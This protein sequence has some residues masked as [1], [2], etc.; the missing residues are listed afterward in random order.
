M[1]NYYM[2]NELIKRKRSPAELLSNGLPLAD[3][4]ILEDLSIN[5]G[6]IWNREVTILNCDVEKLNCMMVYFDKPVTFKN[7]RFKNAIFNFAYFQ[8][9]LLI[10]DCIFEKYLDFEADGH[11]EIHT[12]EGDSQ[13]AAKNF[14]D[15]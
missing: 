2:K 12:L 7:C 4:L 6:E 13:I 1:T 15:L 11:N 3:L 5:G 9:G 10:E 8:K 14:S